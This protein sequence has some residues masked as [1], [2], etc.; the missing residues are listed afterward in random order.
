MSPVASAEAWP[1]QRCLGLRRH[2]L[3]RLFLG[4]PKKT[5]QKHGLLYF[6]RHPLGG[7]DCHATLARVLGNQ[8]K[9]SSEGVKT[10]AYLGMIF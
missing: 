8:D 10:I 1:V 4:S 3:G 6:E 2:A 9:C 7:T 5:T